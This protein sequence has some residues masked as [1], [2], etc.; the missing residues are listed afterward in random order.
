[1]K[2]GD[3]IKDHSMKTYRAW[4]GSDAWKYYGSRDLCYLKD[5]TMAVYEMIALHIYLRFPDMKDRTLGVGDASTRSGP[6]TG[7]PAGFHIAGNSQDLEYYTSE[8]NL[9]QGKGA[10]E[11]WLPDGTLDLKKFDLDRNKVLF[12]KIHQ[13]FPQAAISVSNGILEVMN[14]YLDNRLN[15]IVG[16]DNPIWRHSTHVHIQHGKDINLNAELC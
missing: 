16:D 10:T 2:L 8:K 5:A 12:L 7:H 14:L 4:I 11:I 3:L 1:M 15:Y 9:T 13:C 6:A